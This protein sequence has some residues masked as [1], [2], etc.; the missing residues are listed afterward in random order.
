[1]VITVRMSHGFDGWDNDD[2]EQLSLYLP[3]LIDSLSAFGLNF[4]R[5]LQCPLSLVAT[6][7]SHLH[8]T[9]PIWYVSGILPRCW[10][11][12]LTSWARFSPCN[13][14]W[15][16]NYNLVWIRA[17]LPTQSAMICA[18]CKQPEINTRLRVSWDVW[19]Y[20]IW[21]LMTPANQPLYMDFA[22]EEVL[23]IIS[24]PGQHGTEGWGERTR[25][26]AWGSWLLE[27]NSAQKEEAHQEADTG[28]HENKYDKD[29]EW[30]WWWYI[31]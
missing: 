17:S 5:L 9:M 7:S 20:V 31:L 22:T 4:K 13:S 1:M 29:A 8:Q 24:R 28:H 2:V 6:A 25:V 26:W 3:G 16:Q 30:W 18:V 15:C 14:I 19:F 12:K 27:S 23:A 11:R 21:H 10:E